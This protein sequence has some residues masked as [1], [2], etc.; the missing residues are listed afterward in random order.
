MRLPLWFL[1]TGNAETLKKGT[2][3]VTDS[4]ESRM[5]NE[6]G[7]SKGWQSGMVLY[8]ESREASI[9]KLQDRAAGFGADARKA[10]I[11]TGS[12]NPNNPDGRGNQGFKHSVINLT[13]DTGPG[14]PGAIGIDYNVSNFGT[15]EFVTIRSGDGSGKSGL[16]LTRN[17]GP[18]LVKHVLIEGFDVGIEA[19]GWLYSMTF[20]FI[21]LRGQK[22]AGLTNTQ[23]VLS[24]RKLYSENTVPVIQAT[25]D[26]GLINLVDC[27]FSGGTSSATAIESAAKLN[28]VN[29][30]SSGYGTVITSTTGTKSSVAGGANVT[31]AHYTSDT[32]YSAFPGGKAAPLNLPIEDTPDYHPANFSLWANANNFPSLQ[33]AIDSGKEVIYLPAGSTYKLDE[34]LIIRGNVRKLM[35]LE[36]RIS[37]SPSFKGGPLIRFADGTPPE[38]IIE[39]AGNL[40]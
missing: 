22:V 10:V 26:T 11:R 9:I 27:K 23:S 12:E 31:I 4:L 7:W 3:L 6:N 25:A 8:G 19:K 16:G 34:P 38:V 29:L 33:A 5:P 32:P 24:F 21:T 36:A 1:F 30:I 15:I 40:R 35:G 20:E 18:G 37:Q 13:I 39:L 17:I 14:N 2:Y 28:I